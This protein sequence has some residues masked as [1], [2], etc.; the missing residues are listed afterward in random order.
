[1]LPKA[2]FLSHISVVSFNKKC[3][4][5]PEARND[6]FLFPLSNCIITKDLLKMNMYVHTDPP[7]YLAVGVPY[8]KGPFVRKLV[9]H[10]N[11]RRKDVKK[12]NNFARANIPLSILELKT[13]SP[14]CAKP[15]KSVCLLLRR[16][17]FF[18]AF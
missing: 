8:L 4:K 18:F 17:N 5:W 9:V 13:K 15:L 11:W 1:M 10:Q 2:C 6:A 12:T 16:K 3:I 7:L 14:K